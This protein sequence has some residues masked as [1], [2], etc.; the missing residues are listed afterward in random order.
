MAEEQFEPIRDL[1]SFVADVGETEGIRLYRV[2]LRRDLASVPRDAL[3]ADEWQRNARFVF[4]A[5]RRRHAVAHL[6]LRWL[7]APVLRSQPAALRFA[8]GRH[9]KPHLDSDRDVVFNL[10]HSCDVA[11][12]GI[13]TGP[14]IG[15]DI[16][17]LRPLEQRED[18]A[19]RHYTAGERRE[20]DDAREEHRTE[21][22]LRCWTR[23]EACIKAVG[24]GLSVE[25]ASFEAGIRG[26]RDVRLQYEGSEYDTAV[27][28]IDVGADC[29]AA[30]ARMTG[31]PRPRF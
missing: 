19:R 3:S 15:V 28:S 26:R 9:D 27:D 7:L 23:K 8:L 12:V 30:V 2:D 21:A 31:D 10:S 6:A 17:I 5:D 1:H 16:E 20:I 29:V 4:E 24:S 22:F 25:P 18:L 14:Q 11:L 13:A